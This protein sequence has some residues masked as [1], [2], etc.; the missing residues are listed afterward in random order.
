MPDTLLSAVPLTRGKTL[1]DQVTEVMRHNVIT[2]LW[3]VGEMLPS[4]ITLACDLDVSRTVIREAVSRLKAEGLL[5]S[6]QG[7]GACVASDRPR[8]GFAIPEDDVESLRKLSQ[9]LELRMGLEIEAAALAAARAPDAARIEIKAA[10][11]AFE[12]TSGGGT[13][14]VPDGVRTDL[15]F[16]RAICEATGNDY[17]LGLFNYL[18]ASLRETILAGRLQAIKRG[19]DSRDAVAEHHLI[20]D[21]IAV[22]EVELARDKMRAHL[23]MSSMR[24]LQALNDTAAERTP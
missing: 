3:K 14:R 18:G 8:F 19:S 17:Y 16:H 24:L 12:R 10:A 20:A 13:A 6:R 7:R 9:I 4:E 11:D 23:E 22:G 21:A 15:R 1:S 5:S 2:G